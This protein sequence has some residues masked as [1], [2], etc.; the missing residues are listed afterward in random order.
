MMLRQCSD[1]QRQNH[2]SSLRPPLHQLSSVCDTPKIRV[3]EPQTFVLPQG[4]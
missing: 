4:L 2:W 3:W 1:S